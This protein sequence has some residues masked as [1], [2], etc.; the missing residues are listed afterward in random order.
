MKKIF[1]VFIFVSTL[2]FSE[3]GAFA[4]WEAFQYRP[5][6]DMNE[7]EWKEA[8]EFLDRCVFTEDWDYTTAW[9]DDLLDLPYLPPKFMNMFLSYAV[10]V[11]LEYDVKLPSHSYDRAMFNIQ[12]LKFALVTLFRK[13]IDQSPHRLFMYRNMF[14]FL[15]MFEL[16]E[17]SMNDR[18]GSMIMRRWSQQEVVIDVQ[19]QYYSK[20]FLRKLMRKLFQRLSNVEH[21]NMTYMVA[22][23][24]L[25]LDRTDDIWS[26]NFPQKK[27][28]TYMMRWM[29]EH[30][31]EQ[32]DWISFTDTFSQSSKGHK[33]PWLESLHTLSRFEKKKRFSGF[34][35]KFLFVFEHLAR[36]QCPSS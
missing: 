8:F 11:D 30:T 26:P 27:H 7:V 33:Q 9:L 13:K 25:A 31:Q 3:N 28:R 32:L 17:R 21:L 2:S 34:F 22:G 12:M 10:Q 23:A 36:R 19:T 1:V 16:A 29:L 4:S 24:L 15:F 6:V 14:L 35:S 5:Q 20:R 18:L